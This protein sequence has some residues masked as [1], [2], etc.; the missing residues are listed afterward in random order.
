MNRL[1]CYTSIIVSLMMLPL[2]IRG[3]NGPDPTRALMFKNYANSA[4]KALKA[5]DNML[6][7]A[8][9]QH[10]MTK[11]EVDKTTNLQKEFNEYLTNFD[12]ILTIATEIYAIYYEVDQAVKNLK[13]LKSVTVS[14]PANTLAV[15][16][17]RSKS[18]IYN[19]VIENGIQIANDVAKLLPI[20]KDKDKNTKM[21]ELERIQCI[22]DIRIS[23]RNMNF[24]MRKMNRLIRY[25]TLMDSWYELKGTYHKPK[26]M[27]EICTNSRKR[28]QEK[29]ISANKLNTK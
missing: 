10:I 22:S 27:L 3:Q 4:Y 17:S 19:D 13:E 5:Q 15:A 14:C 29:A 7:V 16:L 11:E 23:L 24:R 21:T 26:S 12:D 9:G 2:N 6:G 20:S 25:T 28:W 8:L 18:H 1:I